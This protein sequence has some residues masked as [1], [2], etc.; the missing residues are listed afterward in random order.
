MAHKFN[1]AHKNILDNEWRREH[2]PAKETLLALGLKVTDT[3]ADIGCGTGY[4]TLPIAEIVDINN[5]VYGLDT[6]QEMVLEVASRAKKAEFENIITLLT[7][8]YDFKLADKQVSFALLVN[9]LHEIEDKAK[10]ITEIKR[11]LQPRGKIAV[12]DW[13][14]EHLEMGPPIAHRL[15]IEELKSLLTVAGF[16]IKQEMSFANYFYGLVGELK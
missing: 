6:S 15:A 11:I 13:D 1:P 7:E 9:V 5:K 12:I 2:V 10:F 14:G 3:A 16:K 8:E 4:F